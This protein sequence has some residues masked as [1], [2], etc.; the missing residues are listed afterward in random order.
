M[1]VHSSSSYLDMMIEFRDGGR[2]LFEVYNERDDM[3]IFHNYRRF[4]YVSSAQAQS[5]KFNTFKSQIN[6]FAARCNSEERFV[7]RTKKLLDE[8][9]AHGYCRATLLNILRNSMTTLID[10]QRELFLLNI[11]KPKKAWARILQ[12]M[13]TT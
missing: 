3:P 10:R 4:H 1:P 2:I 6:R 13:K 11:R 12:A 7:Y 9:V 8:M 5:T